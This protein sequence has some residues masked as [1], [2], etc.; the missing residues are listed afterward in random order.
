MKKLS[1]LII[2]ALV[3][4]AVFVS[5]ENSSTNRLVKLSGA[6]AALPSISISERKTYKVGER[7]PAGGIIFYDAGSTQ[8]SRYRDEFGNTVSYLWRYLEAAPEDLDCYS[9]GYYRPNGKA[10]WVG[11]GIDVGSG[12]ENT[13]S[14]VNAYNDKT[15]YTTLEGSERGEYA[16]RA[17]SD[18]EYTNRE[19]GITYSD[20][21]LPSYA[22][23]YCLYEIRD[24]AGLGDDFYWTSSE[25][26]YEHAYYFCVRSGEEY[27]D[28]GIRE[29]DF[30]VRPVRAFF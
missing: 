20:W 19:T 12:R 7:G 22:E 24:A 15:A 2:A 23:F 6:E 3:T 27:D 5:C 4:A 30:C 29:Y 14:L 8:T 16:A 18:W 25:E 17:C 9:F 10:E 1:T 11:T 21:F 13:S 28:S 26:D